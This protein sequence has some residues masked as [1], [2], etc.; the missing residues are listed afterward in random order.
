M[1]ESQTQTSSALSCSPSA[2]SRALIH[3][4]LSESTWADARTLIIVGSL[5]LLVKSDQAATVLNWLSGPSGFKPKL[6]PVL[7]STILLY[8]LL[9]FLVHAV[10]DLIIWWPIWREI[11]VANEKISRLL[12]AFVAIRFALECGV[13][14]VFAILA[15]R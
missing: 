6:V 11:Q 12:A 5:T 13:P 8:F 7:L 2:G 4:P 15:L 3:G 10:A 1:Q 9:V 14:L